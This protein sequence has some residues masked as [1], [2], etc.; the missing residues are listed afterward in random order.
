MK[1]VALALVSIVWLNLPSLAQ[2]QKGS[3]Y[4]GITGSGNNI[5]DSEDNNGT[6]KSIKRN[7]S[8]TGGLN[9]GYFVKN[10]LS[11]GVTGLYNSELEV[12]PIPLNSSNVLWRAKINIELHARR[13]FMVYPNFGIYPQI[14][15][16]IITGL[17]RDMVRINETLVLLAD[18]ELKGYTA[19]LGMGIT[20]FPF[21]KAK[22]LN[23]AAF[24]NVLGYNAVT[25]TYKAPSTRNK[26]V[27]T[28]F[29][30][31]NTS[32]GINYYIFK[33]SNTK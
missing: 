15:G 16:G 3:L 7:Y 26:E 10:N 29:S 19:N 2:T 30:F 31:F 27:K 4:F 32:V 28:T 11:I 5:F 21:K 9:M 22:R 14:S 6:L 24:I 12:T 33:Q 1:K 13:Y 18:G 23:I 17:A 20:W 25:N 8:F